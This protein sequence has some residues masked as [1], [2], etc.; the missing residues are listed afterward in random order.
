MVNVHLLVVEQVDVVV[1][2]GMMAS[3]PKDD[4]GAVSDESGER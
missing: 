2:M 1:L 4:D 3:V